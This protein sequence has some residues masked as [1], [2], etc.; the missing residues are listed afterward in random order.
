MTEAHDHTDGPAITSG[1]QEPAKPP[2]LRR[3]TVLRWSIG[4][5]VLMGA[6]NLWSTSTST[7]PPTHPNT[8]TVDTASTDPT[9]AIADLQSGLQE[10][11]RKARVAFEPVKGQAIPPVSETLARNEDGGRAASAGA[12]TAIDQEA[13][14]LKRR[15]REA[16]F[17]SSIVPL[18]GAAATP[19]PRQDAIAADPT[20][21]PTVSDFTAEA[22]K[23]LQAS[24]QLAAPPIVHP[25]AS[26]P[27]PEVPARGPARPGLHRVL[28]G[29]EIETG[30]EHDLVIGGPV[31]VLVSAPVYAHDL[32]LVIPKG[33]KVIGEAQPVAAAGE[34][35]LAV[36]F[37]AIQL[38]DGSDLPIDQYLAMNQGGDVGLKSKVNNHYGPMFAASAAV[39]LLSGFGQMVGGGFG[40]RQNGGVTVVSG[41]VS[42]TT[43]QAA[44]QTLNRF[45]NR[46]PTIT[47]PKGHRVRVY[48]KA[49][50]DLPAWDGGR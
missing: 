5:I 34:S 21:E 31:K 18:N 20:R 39:G 11:G 36:L 16:R 42:D 19:A 4:A 1:P 33:S 47:I 30:L 24:G 32:T 9:R 45:S 25:A 3:E 37:H 48:L 46:M 44:M 50:L 41:N 17:A 49:H 29:T 35:R 7:T 2:R 23:A 10:I 38:P 6:L 13:E 43:T 26:T 40:S 8:V 22:V 15:K 14:D 12:A 27:Q 28:E